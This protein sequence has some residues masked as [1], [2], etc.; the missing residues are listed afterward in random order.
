M[1]EPI[2][3]IRI[4][5]GM[6]AVDEAR[7]RLLVQLEAARRDGIRVVKLIHGYGS[8]GTGGALRDALRSSLRKRRREGVIRAF[9]PG[10]KWDIFDANAGLVLEDCPALR[11]DPDLN[12][13]NEGI[14]IVLL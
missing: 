13:Y 9:V 7:R 10:E 11:R 12:R 8:T 14:T 1:P 4:K 6:P 3:T 2:R 5:D